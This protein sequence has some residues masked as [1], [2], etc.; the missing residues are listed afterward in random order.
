MKN[1]GL[2]ITLGIKGICIAKLKV[3][4]KEMR[5]TLI[6]MWRELCDADVVVVTCE[7][8][9]VVISKRTANP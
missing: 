7:K 2:N 3:K 8:R 9:I 1:S 5:E 6:V 4:G